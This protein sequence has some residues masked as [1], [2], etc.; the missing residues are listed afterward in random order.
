[1]RLLRKRPSIPAT[2]GDDTV[3]QDP[4]TS[5]SRRPEETERRRERRHLRRRRGVALC[6]IIGLAYGIFHLVFRTDVLDPVVAT[7]APLGDLV[8]SVAADPTRAW[9]ALGS[10]VIPL[11]G[12]YVMLFEN[13]S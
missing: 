11:V 8:D 10:I 13:D 1:M 5:T 2:G 12:T 3:E 4:G 7:V 6:F 9:V